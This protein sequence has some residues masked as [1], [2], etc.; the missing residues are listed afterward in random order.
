MKHIFLVLTLLFTVSIS[1]PAYAE[2]TDKHYSPY[3]VVPDLLIFRPVGF[4]CT[5]V[6]TGLFAVMSPLTAFASISPPHDA[7]E[8]AADILIMAPARY[9]FVRPLGDMS[10]TDY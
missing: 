6:G 2:E 3:F 4:V 9:T 1:L 7:F 5:V 10:E 8:K